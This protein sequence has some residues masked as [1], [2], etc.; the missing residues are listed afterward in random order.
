MKG[1]V[2]CL[3]DGTVSVRGAGVSL[4]HDDNMQ[5]GVCISGEL[6]VAREYEY[7]GNR[8]VK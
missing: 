2:R 7:Q 6:M 4:R 3:S 8:H 5:A 1:G